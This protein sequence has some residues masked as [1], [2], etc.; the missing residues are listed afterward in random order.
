MKL[1]IFLWTLGTVATAFRVE[2]YGGN[3]RKIRKECDLRVLLLLTLVGDA[4]VMSAF[5]LFAYVDWKGLV[6]ACCR[7]VTRPKKSD[8][9]VSGE[10]ESEPN[11]E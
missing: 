3:G 8:F 2:E 1:M 4:L 7:W 5:Y 11:S 6:Q 9:E 10:P